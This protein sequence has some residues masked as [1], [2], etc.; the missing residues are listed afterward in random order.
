[1]RL[2]LLF[3]TVWL[4]PFFLLAD[5]KLSQYQISV[6]NWLD[7]QQKR[8]QQ[9]NFGSLVN[10]L[11][12][13]GQLK[14]L[15]TQLF[16]SIPLQLSVRTDRSGL[17]GWGIRPGDLQAQWSFKLS[18]S[19]SPGLGLQFPLGY[20]TGD[21]WYGPQVFYMILFSKFKL[22]LDRRGTA[23]MVANIYF[24][25]VVIGYPVIPTAL[26]SFGSFSLDSDYKLFFNLK[27]GHKT[28]IEI[29]GLFSLNKW[30]WNLQS[31]QNIDNI[32]SYQNE[33]SLGF[34]PNYYLEI[35]TAREKKYLGFKLGVG[36]LWKWLNT[37]KANLSLSLNANLYYIF[38]F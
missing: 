27:G 35:N 18:D 9:F 16:L 17:A 19:F 15:E 36:P 26:L 22:P 20:E 7:Y 25:P 32:N 10:E 3:L 2:K 21:E 6:N 11:Y 34:V 30:L 38:Y 33:Y 24:K 8:N 4:L 29:L 1:M 37:E 28:G 23:M 14:H 31:E 12:I 13:N 5:T